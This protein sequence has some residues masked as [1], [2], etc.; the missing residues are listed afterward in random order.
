MGDTADDDLA[1]LP[2]E[3]KVSALSGADFWTTAGAGSA[4]G[5][6]FSD[7]PNGVRR[8]A[9]GADPLGLSASLPATC[10]PAG[11]AMGQ[12]WDPELAER[13]GRA[14]A[15]ECREMGVD[16]LLGPAIN[17]KRDPRAGRNS[18]YLSE[19]PWLSGF[20]CAPS[21]ASSASPT[22]GP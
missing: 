13:V 20:S 3:R 10:F 2:L 15:G 14:L 9:R 6:V 5:I 11:V 1:G 19:D 16:V 17:I 7:A 21:S 4:P 22:R 18:E 12:T 8:Q